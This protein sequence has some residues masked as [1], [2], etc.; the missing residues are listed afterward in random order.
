MGGAVMVLTLFLVAVGG[1]SAFL[2]ALLKRL[3][4]G[5][6]H[7]GPRAA[8]SSLRVTMAACPQA[9]TPGALQAGSP[10]REP[11]IR[12]TT[13]RAIMAIPAMPG[14]AAPVAAG[15]A[16]AGAGATAEAAG[17]AAV[18]E[19]EATI[20]DRKPAVDWIFTASS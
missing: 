20:R 18:V 11:P 12:Y 9:A 8:P 1:I 10:A 15:T 6:R 2:F 3:E 14:R 19:A 17:M 7:G 13:V 16:V 5:M 4:R